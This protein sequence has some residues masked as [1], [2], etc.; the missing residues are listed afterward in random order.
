MV[1]ISEQVMAKE[2]THGVSLQ[3]LD[4]E[5]SSLSC[6]ATMCFCEGVASQNFAGIIFRCLGGAL[7][8]SKI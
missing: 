2:I 3:W 5:V 7:K 1:L 8:N 4:K 6:P